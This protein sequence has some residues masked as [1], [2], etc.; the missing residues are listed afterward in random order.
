MDISGEISVILQ[1]FEWGS[2]K[3]PADLSVYSDST[4]ADKSSNGK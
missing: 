2:S 3:R 4:L 1:L